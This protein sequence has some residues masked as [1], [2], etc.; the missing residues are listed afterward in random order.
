MEAGCRQIAELISKQAGGIP[1]K[2]IRENRERMSQM[3][4]TIREKSNEARILAQ[5]LSD[6]KQQLRESNAQ[7]EQL[8]GKAGAEGQCT[9]CGG[10]ELNLKRIR[11]EM[12]GLVEEN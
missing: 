1:S 6:A 8:R 3:E 5:N 12:E 2:G 11:T 10:M 7:V 9:R 4:G